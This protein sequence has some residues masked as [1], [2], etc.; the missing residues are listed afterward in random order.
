MTT[1]VYTISNPLQGVLSPRALARGFIVKSCCD[2]KIHVDFNRETNNG[3][4]RIGLAIFSRDDKYSTL[5]FPLNLSG[6]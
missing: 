2:Q 5:G 6:L 1:H 4:G 3:I